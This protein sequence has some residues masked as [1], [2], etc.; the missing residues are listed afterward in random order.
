ME[1]YDSRLT[2]LITD[3]ESVLYCEVENT[4]YLTDIDV[5]CRFLG[6]HGPGST[7]A[8]DIRCFSKNVTPNSSG[9]IAGL[10]SGRNRTSID[11]NVVCC[12]AQSVGFNRI[13]KLSDT[14]VHVE[15]FKL[16]DV[17]K[18]CYDQTCSTPDEN[19]PVFTE[20]FKLNGDPDIESRIDTMVSP[21]YVAVDVPTA[22][23]ENAE[24]ENETTT[25]AFD[26]ESYMSILNSEIENMMT[27]SSRNMKYLGYTSRFF[28]APTRFL[29]SADPDL[30]VVDYDGNT[31]EQGR[32]WTKNIAME[33]PLVHFVP[34]LPTY[35]KDIDKANK[36]VLREYVKEKTSG[37]EV[38][39]SV[40]ERVTGIEGRYFDFVA[41]YAE[42]IKYV[43]ALCRTCAIY[44]GIGDKTVPGTD[45]KYKYYNYGNWQ[46]P[47][48]MPSTSDGNFFD[49]SGGQTEEYS[50]DDIG[51]NIVSN[52]EDILGAIGGL[53]KEV[54]KD[55]VGGNRSVKMYVDAGSSF[56]ES[57][58]NQTAQSQIAGL[59]DTGESVM[60]ELGYWAGG[61]KAG[62]L[63]ETA[64][65]TM[66]T[67]ID[68]L[69]TG[70]LSTIGMGE[71]QLTNLADYANYII[72][73]SNIVFPEM[74]Q[75]S[76]YSKSYN[77][78]VNL[79]SPY[80]DSE[81]I[82]LH[83]IMPLMFI[84]GLALPR[85]TSANSFA[86]PMMVRVVSKGWFSCDMGMIDSISID[87]G[88]SDGWNASGMPMSM[89]VSIG[90]KDLYSSMS[91]AKTSQPGLFFNNNA[92]IEFLAATCG[93]DTIQPNLSLKIETLVNALL[94]TVRD[95]PSNVYNRAIE[96]LNNTI[97]KYTRLF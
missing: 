26:S 14:I 34:G 52:A 77:F 3:L 96:G 86:S 35:L 39:E 27:T 84:L 54:A 69:A 12:V 97:L 47:K 21:D 66:G 73:G 20:Y 29:K 91:M 55:I 90:V 70:L 89:K 56:S 24:S 95:I 9:Y 87:K 15:V 44:M 38:S 78:T 49:I 79:V 37:S 31:I 11:A 76:S 62:D 74:W 60:K 71:T 13:A 51:K 65:I 80:G 18:E 40:I 50:G 1:G 10:I 85:Q 8:M 48:A 46:D 25:T 53:A 41:S 75:D 5:E 19:I 72:S 82:F 68:K 93:V 2:A 88:S 45:T 22:A 36:D 33:A 57:L 6:S 28:G 58:S 43:N 64:A 16:G 92:L 94:T 42:Y 81:S 7:S 63:L 30:S 61:G 59:F 83:E 4:D 67:A 32:T 17:V 23:E